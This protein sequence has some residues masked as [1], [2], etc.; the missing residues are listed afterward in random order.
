[1]PT[2]RIT[3][4]ICLPLLLAVAAGAE[5][6]RE[7]AAWSRAPESCER[8]ALVQHLSHEDVRVRSAALDLLELITGRDFGLDPWLA[9]ADVPADV[10]KSLEEWSKAEELAGKVRQS[11]PGTQIEAI[12]LDDTGHLSAALKKADLLLQMTS[13]GLHDEDPAPMPLELLEV[14]SSL[15]IFDAIYRPTPLLKR[16]QTLG[17]AAADGSDML[18]YQ[19]AASFEIWTGKSAPLEAMRR[20]FNQI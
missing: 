3:P 5:P 11:L 2:T 13:L 18:I 20:G 10:R 12:A 15:R 9:P 14:N 19:G 4:Y 7:I 6:L 16:A 17:L 8:R 1:M